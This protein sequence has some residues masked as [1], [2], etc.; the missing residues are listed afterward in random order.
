MRTIA[1]SEFK[2]RALAILDEV[3]ASGEEIVV[4]KRGNPVARVTAYVRAE[5]RA[6][7]GWL[8]HTLVHMG[9]IVAP[10]GD[11]DWETAA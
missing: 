1:A 3:A 7:P 6:A 8:S 5:E 2:A 11:A 4:T 9:D 10:L